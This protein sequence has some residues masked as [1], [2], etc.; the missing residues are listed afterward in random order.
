MCITGQIDAHNDCVREKKI[1]I[2]SGIKIGGKA[3]KPNTD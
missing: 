1:L 3:K 2:V